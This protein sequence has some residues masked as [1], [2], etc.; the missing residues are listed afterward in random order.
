VLPTLFD[1]L[2]LAEKN[3][4]RAAAIRAVAELGEHGAKPIRD[5][6]VAGREPPLNGVLEALALMGERA[7]FAVP[8]LVARL[9]QPLEP[10]DVEPTVRTIA[11]IGAPAV[12]PV[13]KAIP[14]AKTRETR[15]ISIFARMGPLAKEALPWLEKMARHDHFEIAQ[16][17]REAIPKVKGGS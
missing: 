10:K 7:Q 6:I 2:A 3:P 5:V 14:R 4:L 9:V 8:E 16:A 15:F 1:L 12:K 13:I 17:A 11:A